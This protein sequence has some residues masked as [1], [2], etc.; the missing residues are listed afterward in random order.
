MRVAP[1]RPGGMTV[2]VLTQDPTSSHATQ[3]M[4]AEQSAALADFARTCKAA[5]RAVSLYPG[6]HPT[7]AATLGR[8]VIAVDRIARGSDLVLTVYPTAL[9]IDDRTPARPDPTIGE[10]AALLHSRLIGSL[11]IQP[12]ASSEDWRQL[13]LVLARPVEDLLA[14]GGPTTAWTATGREHFDII[15]IDYAAVLKERTAG[16]AAT[17]DRLLASCLKGEALTLDETAIDLLLSAFADTTS[18][19]ALIDRLND[20]AE[21]ERSSVPAR[22]ATVIKLLKA[23][24]AAAEAR[25]Q[26]APE[27]MVDT[28]AQ[29]TGHFTPDMILGLLA[30]RESRAED[31]PLAGR[32]VEGMTD[33]SIASFV[34]RSVTSE[35]GA[36]ARLAHAFEA[37]VPDAARRSPLLALAHDEA[38][39]GELGEDPR[40]EE[41]WEGAT[42]MM[43]ETYSDEGWVPDDYAREL[44]A[45]RTQAVE[46]ERLSDDPPERLAEWLNTISERAVRELDL[47][48][49][50]DLLRLESKP[51][52][53]TP[54]AVIAARELEQRTM[55]GEV[56]AAA[57]VAESL[58][59]TATGDRQDLRQPAERVLEQLASSSFARHVTGLLRKAS[60]ADSA[61]ITRLCHTVGP[62]MV[63]ALAEALATEGHVPTIRRL[64]D[65]LIGFGAA[66]RHAVE[67]L[68]SATNPAVRRTA[69]DLLRLFG[70]NDALRELTAMLTDAD[71]QVKQDSI[72][73]IVQIGTREA[74]AVLERACAADD[75]TRTIVVAELVSLRDPKTIPPLCH[76]LTTSPVTGATAA[77]H[78]A[79]IEALASLRAHPDST[80][81][82]Q[83]AL[84]RGVWW[85]PRRTARLRQAAAR[86][87]RRL[88]SPD[89][90]DVLED[91]A[92]SG[93]RG[94]RKA[95]AAELASFGS[96]GS[97]A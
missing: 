64:K 61:S 45:A 24:I 76:A 77:Q 6:T 15:E 47:N 9:A 32:I 48:L 66:G 25:R 19:G 54:I 4:S 70:G 11:R 89:A 79:I 36:S 90:K 34:A 29:S 1:A 20:K 28:L 56:S 95:A 27:Q 71:P 33:A 55:T 67:P 2:H 8:L 43:L 85:A 17:W 42:R 87:L 97:G 69:I 31:A 91:A 22:V 21:S 68:R 93:D 86:G 16:D 83:T 62:V 23:A 46:V 10:L 59:A 39:D 88:G 18:L 65:V 96:T 94:V 52:A 44:S 73:A 41:V 63:K 53:W 3:P 80:V 40:F 26:S 51:D 5:A 7:I 84:Y 78:E 14:E 35:R 49:T 57:R 30:H 58:A 74:Y 13:L 75:Q 72:R 12:G 50:L 37:L 92:R 60:E 82:L 81:A 38:R